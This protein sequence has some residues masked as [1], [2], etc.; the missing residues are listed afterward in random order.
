MKEIHKKDL[1]LFKLTLFKLTTA[2]ECC[3]YGEWDACAVGGVP[4][5]S[6]GSLLVP[7]CVSRE[8]SRLAGVYV[9][10]SMCLCFCV[11][12]SVSVSMC[13]CVRETVRVRMYYL[14]HFACLENARG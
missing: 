14:S 1:T 9:Y 8:C 4:F 2:G 3:N 13:V 5:Y 12:V 6:A 7:L 11:S 10:V